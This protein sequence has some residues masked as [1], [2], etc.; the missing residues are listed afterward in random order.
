VILRKLSE[1]KLIRLDICGFKKKFNH[2]INL[3]LTIF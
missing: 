2:G 3:I 1:L